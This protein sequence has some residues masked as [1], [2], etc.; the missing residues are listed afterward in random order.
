[1]PVFGFAGIMLMQ[2]ILSD[3]FSEGTIWYLARNS[4]I[5][6]DA[7]IVDMFFPYVDQLIPSSTH[8]GVSHHL[9]SVLYLFRSTLFEYDCASCYAGFPLHTP[10]TILNQRLLSSNNYLLI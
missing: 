4:S 9:Y 2:A 7:N 3:E 1:V 5:S 8:S 10:I 6:S